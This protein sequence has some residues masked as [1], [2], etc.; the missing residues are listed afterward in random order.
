MK[1]L[2]VNKILF[3]NK[4]ERKKVREVGILKKDPETIREQIEKLEMMSKLFTVSTII[5][6]CCLYLKYGW[7]LDFLVWN[8]LEFVC[9]YILATVWVIVTMWLLIHSWFITTKLL[10][11]FISWPAQVLEKAVNLHL[12]CYG[13]LVQTSS[14]CT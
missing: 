1:C 2:I 10:R 11:S 13:G 5:V 3:Q 6:H 4:K 12:L 9:W 7:I 8:L 14:F